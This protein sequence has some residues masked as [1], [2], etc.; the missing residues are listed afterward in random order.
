MSIVRATPKAVNLLANFNYYI[1]NSMKIM[2]Q[3]GSAKDILNQELEG[4][5]YIGNILGQRLVRY[6]RTM[7]ASGGF[8]LAFG[9]QYLLRRLSPPGSSIIEQ[10]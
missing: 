9:E 4:R 8:Y 2:T 3:P 6:K 1:T 10:S 7:F 5:G